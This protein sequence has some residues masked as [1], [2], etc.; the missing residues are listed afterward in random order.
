MIIPPPP[1]VPIRQSRRIHPFRSLLPGWGLAATVLLGGC[2]SSGAGLRSVDPAEIPRLETEVARDQGNQELLVRLGAAYRADGRLDDAR[3]TLERAVRIDPAAGP[4]A[5]YLALTYEDLEEWTAA[6]VAYDGYA[7][8]GGDAALRTQASRRVPVMRRR[9]LEAE[10]RASLSQEAQLASRAPEPRTVAVFPFLYAGSDPDL[11]PLGRAL[12][13][14]VV[15]DL[16]QTDRLRVLERSRVQILLDE[17]ALGQTGRVD[18]TTVARSGRILG[19]GRIIQG[20][21]SGNE[22]LLVMEGAVVPVGDP[23]ATVS[24]A[25]TEQDRLQ[26]FFEAQKR[27]VLGL[28]E[29]LGIE[30]TPAERERVNQRPT[31]S[32]QALLAWGR[33]LEAEDRGDYA[34]AAAFYAEAAATDPGFENAQIRAVD[35]QASAAALGVTTGALQEIALTQLP[36]ASGGQDLL[37]QQAY[38][39]ELERLLPGS[40][41]RNPIPEVE[42]TE[43]V[44]GGRSVLVELLLRRP[45]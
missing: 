31:Q 36:P 40:L 38:I 41:D 12:A 32:V 4:A 25:L 29:A 17:I 42:G 7:R 13:E 43:G 19:A 9:A 34:A 30:L 26:A 20:T 16:A 27:L 35:A 24:P 14:L 3:A 11:S 8:T 5:F 18:S 10:V 28:Y 21:V 45:R 37:V 15:T 33:G 23:T 6:A 44:G 22:A 1:E 2:A 39:Q